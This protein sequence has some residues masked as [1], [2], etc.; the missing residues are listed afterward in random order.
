MEN[1]NKKENQNT[2]LETC[3]KQAEEY[4]NNWKRERADFVNYKKKE[5]ILTTELW[6]FNQATLAAMD[7]IRDLLTAIYNYPKNK[8]AE[9]SS[10]QQFMGIRAL[11]MSIEQAWGQVGIRKIAVEGQQFDPTLHEVVMKDEDGEKLEEI[12]PGYAIGDR[13]IRSARVKIIK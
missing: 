7:S 1:N 13:V 6:V 9:L 12:A 11:Q 5:E 10:L 8:K 4:L 2:E 3:K